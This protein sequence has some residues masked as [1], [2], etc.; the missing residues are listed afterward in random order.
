MARFS[1]RSPSDALKPTMAPPPPP[2]IRRDRGGM[3]SALSGFLTFFVVGAIGLVAGVVFVEKQANEPGPLQSDKVVMIPK[4]IGTGEIATLLK[5]E[6]V[7]NQTFLFELQAFISRQRGP[8][9]AGEFLFKARTSIDSAIDTL[10]QGKPILHS[11]T[12]PEGLTSEQIVQRIRDNEILTGDIGEPPRE[13]TL[14]PDTYKF[15]RGETRQQVINRMQ[16]AQ[17]DTL[18][19][20]WARRSPELPIKTPQ[21]L[22]ILA[23]IVEKETGRADERSRVAGVFINRLAK[24]MKLQSDPTIVYGLVGGKGTLGRGILRT[25]IEKATPYNTYAIEGL[26]PGP[27]ANPGKAA[28]EAVANPSRTKELYFVADGTGGHVFAETLDQHQKNVQRWRQIEK[29]RATEGAPVVD[30]VEPPPG[31]AETRGD[32]GA[33]APGAP[34]QAGGLGP[35]PQ[36]QAAG[37]RQRA[38]DASEGTPRDPLRNRSFDLNSAKTVPALRAQ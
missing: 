16:R 27:I 3:L 23:S 11:I 30:R 32:T 14:L 7:I 25:E 15:E 5:R 18:N 33:A 10:I 37:A 36:A 4:S 21:E 1:P 12:F 31:P 24:R 6:G 17:R 8:L 22:V 9:K 34:S 28:L 2:R 29:A 13:G 26:P 38:F 20:I 19:Q 35:A